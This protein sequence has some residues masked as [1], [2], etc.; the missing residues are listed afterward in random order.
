MEHRETQ[1]IVIVEDPH[2]EKHMDQKMSRGARIT[3]REQ[4]RQQTDINT[5]RSATHLEKL[6]QLH[7]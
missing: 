6:K 7:C 5:R 4:G 1:E 3:A 2:V